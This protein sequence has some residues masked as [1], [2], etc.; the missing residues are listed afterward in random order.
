MAKRVGRE[1]IIEATRRA[2]GVEGESGS[3]SRQMRG[4]LA[5][6]E[7]P[8]GV[9]MDLPDLAEHGE[10]GLGQGQGALL[11]A[12]ADYPQEHLPG[13][14][15]GE[16]QFDG[17]ADPQTAGVAQGETAAIDRL[18]DRRDQAATVL[19]ASDVGQAFA[20]GRADF[21]FVSSGQS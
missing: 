13:V 20:K 11:V 6:G 12:F 7:E 1:R 2:G 15:G 19:V 21:F 18:V 14:D 9:A 4:A 8:L 3:R 5:I 16:G 10:H 17:F